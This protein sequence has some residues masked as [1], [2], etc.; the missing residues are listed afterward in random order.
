M[1]YEYPVFRPDLRPREKKIHSVKDEK[2]GQKYDVIIIG[3][4]MGGLFAGNYLTKKGMKTLT[5][6]HH[7]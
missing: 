4:G 5:C 2:M 1:S 6:E 7:L 3:A